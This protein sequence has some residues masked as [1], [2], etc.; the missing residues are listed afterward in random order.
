MINDDRRHYVFEQ[1]NGEYSWLMMGIILVLREHGN[2]STKIRRVT[3]KIWS[4]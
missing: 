3:S 4:R 1:F 2:Y